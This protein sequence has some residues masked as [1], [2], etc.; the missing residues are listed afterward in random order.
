[1]SK[2][3]QSF[4]PEFKLEAV[5]LVTEKGYSVTE[6]CQALGIGPTALRRWIK[7]VEREQHGV[8]RSGSQALTPEQR[9]IQ[10]L[11]KRI[12]R[13]EMEKEILKKATALLMSDEIKYKR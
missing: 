12:Q 3:R 4:T 6:A 2:R 5:S 1:M 13:L 10:E 8:V 9:Q 11:Q 7:Q